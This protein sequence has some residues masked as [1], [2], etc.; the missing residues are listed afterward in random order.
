MK[1]RVRPA[2]FRRQL[3]EV[4]INSLCGQV[5]AQ[6]IGEHQPRPLPQGPSPELLPDLRGPVPPK[7]IHHGAGRSDRAALAVLWRNQVVLPGAAAFLLELPADSDGP[8]VEVHTVPAQAQGL[9]L[10][11][12]GEQGDGI[13]GLEPVPP[14][15]LEESGDLCII[16][17]LQLWPLHPGQL[18]GIGGIEAEIAHLDGLLERLVEHA[19]DVLYRL[20]RQAGPAP[21]RFSNGIVEALDGGSG[22]SIQPDRSQGGENMRPDHCLVGIRRSGLHAAQILSLPD[23]QPLAQG[24]ALRG[25]VGA[26]VDLC[27]HLGQL[28][29]D[30][31]L[32][33]A[34]DAALNLPAGAGI[35]SN[36]EAGFPPSVLPLADA[37][38]ACR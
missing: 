20:C 32:R 17:R 35:P 30:L 26:L 12:T 1:P 21:F 38:A 7:E 23:L 10:P 11:H 8:P 37:P 3:F 13:Q 36:G 25:G 34:V 29:P 14:D 9:P 2:D 33:A 15:G 18:A 6:V 16:Q 5:V 28:L 4:E 22:Q 31:P 24:D 19:V 27:H